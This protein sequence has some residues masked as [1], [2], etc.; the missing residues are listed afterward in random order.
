M[1]AYRKA[2][3]RQPQRKMQPPVARWTDPR[4][5]WEAMRRIP[6]MAL[7][8]RDFN[9]IPAPTTA[10]RP[11]ADALY[12]KRQAQLAGHGGLLILPSAWSGSGVMLQSNPLSP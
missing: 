5:C 10:R 11:G 6:E 12:C 9:H 3:A 4:R 2:F 8:D 1:L 7:S